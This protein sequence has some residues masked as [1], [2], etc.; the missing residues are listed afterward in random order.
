MKRRNFLTKLT[1]IPLVASFDN[2]LSKDN[3][4]KYRNY[5]EGGYF[6]YNGYCYPS[7]EIKVVDGYYYNIVNKISLGPVF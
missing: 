5:S 4:Q 7:D 2:V 1:A 6:C 3:S